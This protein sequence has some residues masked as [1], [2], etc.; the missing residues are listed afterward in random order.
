MLLLTNA[1]VCSCMLMYAEVFLLTISSLKVRAQPR[2]VI[3]HP[4]PQ[5]V[6]EAGKSVY[7]LYQYKSTNTDASG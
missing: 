5:E 3:G 6:P 4:L 7:L 2:D 1:D